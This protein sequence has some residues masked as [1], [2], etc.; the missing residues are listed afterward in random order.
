[1]N[2]IKKGIYVVHEI[3]TCIIDHKICALMIIMLFTE[4]CCQWFNN[5]KYVYSQILK[6]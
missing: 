1:M 4:E 6:S 5:N 2:A 3:V